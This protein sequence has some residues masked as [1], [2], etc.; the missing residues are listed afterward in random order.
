MGTVMSER[1]L[2]AH[3]SK[4]NSVCM[5]KSTCKQCIWLTSMIGLVISDR[6]VRLINNYALQNLH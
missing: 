5:E 4:L 3:L 2:P 6:H 1:N